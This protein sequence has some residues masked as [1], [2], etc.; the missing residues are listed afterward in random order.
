MNM[1]EK[2]VTLARLET[3]PQHLSIVIGGKT[4][5][6][7]DLKAH[8]EQETETGEA[9]VDMTMAGLRMWKQL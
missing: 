5:N 8:V 2:K 4:L 9:V 1:D 6:K 7:P 3:V